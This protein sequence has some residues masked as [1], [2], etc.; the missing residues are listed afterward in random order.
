MK[1]FIK[2]GKIISYTNG[3]SA[4]NSG[5]VVVISGVGVGIATGDIANGAEGELLMEGIVSVTKNA[6]SPISFG[7]P[8]FWDAGSGYVTTTPGSHQLIGYCAKAAL[9]ADTS[10]QVALVP[11]GDTDPGNLAQAGNVDALGGSLTGTADGDL[12]DV[13]DIALST[14]DS[15]TDAAVNAAVNAAVGEINEQLKEIQTTLN[16]E[17]AALKAAGLQ[18]S[19]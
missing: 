10:V 2:P 12:A 3:G 4:I 17:I 15:Y 7:V 13:A 19:S 14:G 9:S 6:G 8:L 18:A 16:A 1:N 11:M 5:D